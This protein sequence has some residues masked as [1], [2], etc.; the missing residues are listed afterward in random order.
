MGGC[1]RL[2]TGL[3][4]AGL[5]VL[6]SEARCAIPPPHVPPWRHSS[7]ALHARRAHGYLRRFLERAADGALFDRA[8]P[9]GS[10]SPERSIDGA[11]RRFR[12]GR[13]SRCGRLSFRELVVRLGYSGANAAER[14]R[15][16]GTARKCDF[17]GLGAGRE[18]ARGRRFEWAEPE[19]RV[20]S[21]PC[22]VSG[23]RHGLARRNQGVAER[24]PD[25][26]CRPPLFRRRWK[27]GG[28]GRERPEEDDFQPIYQPAGTGVVAEG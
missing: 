8:G 7:R 10:P 3:H 23:F 17:R 22:A 5:A 9:A 26:L 27:R 18:A 21:R 1:S 28:P 11:V 15:T 2:G 25:R 24:R 19:D 14:R 12:N 6:Q 20:P 13:N 16:P 4:G